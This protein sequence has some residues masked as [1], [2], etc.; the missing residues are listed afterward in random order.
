MS[1]IHGSRGT[2]YFAHQFKPRFVE[3]ALLADPEMLA[4][5]AAINRQVQEHRRGGR[6]GGVRKRHGGS[7]YLFAA[8]MRAQPARAVF[9]VGGPPAAA[10]AEVLGEGRRIAVEGGRF[11]DRFGPYDVRLYRIRSS[12]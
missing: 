9:E 12:P 3:A 11:E 6:V 1:I 10:A 8:C 5:V 4:A 2:I 7:T